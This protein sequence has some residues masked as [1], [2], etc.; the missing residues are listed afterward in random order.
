MNKTIN[1]LRKVNEGKIT[2]TV[3]SISDKERIL[4]ELAR[5]SSPVQ[6]KI[7]AKN[8]D[9]LH[10]SVCIVLEVLYREGR[11]TTNGMTGQYKKWLLRQPSATEEEEK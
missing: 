7:I 9:I 6:S 11:I 4:A 2:K 10:Q 5:H 1:R 3:N 8:L